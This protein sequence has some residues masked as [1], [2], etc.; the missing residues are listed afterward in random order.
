MPL[1]RH[2]SIL[3]KGEQHMTNW[4]PQHDPRRSAG[5]APE[6]PPQW[7][8]QR[9]AQPPQPQYQQPYQPPAPHRRPP[10]QGGGYGLW[11]GLGAVVVAAVA[12]SAFYVLHG[13]SPSSSSPAAGSA[14]QAAAQPETEAGVRS[15]AT[16]FYAMYSAGQWPQAWAGLSPATQQAVPEATWAAVHQQCTSK[17]AGL[18]REI[19]GVTMAGST[20]V[21]TETVAGALGKLGTVADAWSYSGGRWGLTLPASSTGIFAHGSVK[22]DVAASKADGDCAS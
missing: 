16:A 10:R 9:Y 17:T 21:V 22:A 20:A 8:G 2:T 19:K 6:P 12:G 3:F 1:R 11:I 7:Q 18:A 14:A 15:A 4:Q 13:S 5:R